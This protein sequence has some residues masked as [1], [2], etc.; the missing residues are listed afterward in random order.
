[1]QN[2]SNLDEAR[3]LLHVYQLTLSVLERMTDFHWPILSDADYKTHNDGY[4]PFRTE[5]RSPIEFAVQVD[6]RSSEFD[7]FCIQRRK[8]LCIKASLS[9]VY[10]HLMRQHIHYHVPPYPPDNT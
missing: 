9:P 6:T 5:V 8:Y 3:E 4:R 2:I 10:Q 1:M 7:V